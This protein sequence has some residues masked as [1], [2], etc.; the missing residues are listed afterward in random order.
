MYLIS[1]YICSIYSLYAKLEKFGL[2]PH[3]RHKTTQTYGNHA[4]TIQT[5][6]NTCAS[7]LP[8]VLEANTSTLRHGNVDRC[9]SS[10]RDSRFPGSFW[11]ISG[12][13]WPTSCFQITKWHSMTFCYQ[14]IPRWKNGVVK[15]RG[16][17]CA[18]LIL[19]IFPCR[20]TIGPR[21]QFV[22][23]KRWLHIQGFGIFQ[24]IDSLLN[25]LWFTKAIHSKSSAWLKKNELLNSNSWSLHLPLLP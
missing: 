6:S 25:L 21:N 17:L 23:L 20:M 7:W 9:S 11:K 8:W 15:L 14:W 1:V 19:W 13:N 24:G 18:G 2:A 16:K 3:L 4:S 22:Q 5:C 12:T 10:A